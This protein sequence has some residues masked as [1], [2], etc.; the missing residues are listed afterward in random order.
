[1][2][3]QLQSEEPSREPPTLLLLASMAFCDTTVAASEL[4]KKHDGE[5]PHTTRFFLKYARDMNKSGPQ[6]FSLM[7]SY[8]W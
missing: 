8:D 1:M 7:E 5:L 2:P 4:R 6:D 3:Q